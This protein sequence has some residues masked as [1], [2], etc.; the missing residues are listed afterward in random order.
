MNNKWAMDRGYATL[1]TGVDNPQISF[2]NFMQLQ[3]NPNFLFNELVLK[4]SPG[5]IDIQQKFG[6]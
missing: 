6:V 5:F 3:K 4:H 1:F 2:E